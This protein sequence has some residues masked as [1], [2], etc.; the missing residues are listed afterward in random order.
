[1][2]YYTARACVVGYP[3][4]QRGQTV[5]LLAYAFDGSNPSPTTTLIFKIQVRAFISFKRLKS[6]GGKYPEMRYSKTEVIRHESNQ[7]ALLRGGW[8]P[9]WNDARVFAGTRRH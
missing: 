9:G 8:W 4:G 5:N 6:I 7:N 3:S 1:M 2:A